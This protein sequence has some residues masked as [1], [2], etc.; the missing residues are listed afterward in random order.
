MLVRI[1]VNHPRQVYLT[2]YSVV[3][4]EAND[5]HESKSCNRRGGKK[6]NMLHVIEQCTLAAVID[7]MQG[8]YA[9]QSPE[10]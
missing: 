5:R 4:L 10:D 7:N 3:E 2:L 1:I 8:D 9:R 6:E